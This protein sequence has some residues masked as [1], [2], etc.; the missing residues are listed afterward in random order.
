[1][2]IRLD[3]ITTNMLNS[4]GTLTDS[5]VRITGGMGD[6][7]VHNKSLSFRL[8]LTSLEIYKKVRKLF[9]EFFAHK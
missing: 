6:I 2:E 5:T 3:Q 8:S 7:F 4:K 9:L 1:M